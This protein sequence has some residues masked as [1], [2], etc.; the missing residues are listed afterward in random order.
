MTAG[1]IKAALVIQ[2]CP[3]GEFGHNL[4]STLKLVSTAAKK[5]A[6]LVVFPEMNLTGYLTGPEIKNI[7]RP[8]NK[9]LTER[10]TTLAT[11]YKIDILVGLAEQ[12]Q[13]SIYASHLIFSSDGLIEKYRKIHTAPFEKKYFTHGNRVVVFSAFG[14]KFGIQLCYDAH[15]PELSLSMALKGADVILIPH[16]SPRGTSQEKFDS[17]TRHLRARAFD[18]GVYVAACNQAGTNNMGL[19]FPGLCLLIGP[20]GNILYQSVNDPKNNLQPSDKNSIHII[21]LNKAVIEHVR[22]HKMRY[23]LPNRRSDLFR[24]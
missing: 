4:D 23:F 9:E 20:D 5:K 8:V 12:S 19:E 16:A 14:F 6:K 13:N 22:M 3:A 1:K 10:F 24:L 7:S 17:W 15:F 21:E 11:K 18:N 2:N